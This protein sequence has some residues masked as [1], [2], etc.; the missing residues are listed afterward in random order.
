MT[1]L[2]NP[3]IKLFLISLKN[4]QA[5]TTN[6]L[7]YFTR[8][9]SIIGLS[10]VLLLHLNCSVEPIQT[11][12]SSIKQSLDTLTINNITGF[13]YQVSPDI[14][15]YQKLYIGDNNYFSFP[16]SLLKFS[17]EKA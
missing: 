7:M 9:I 15:S 13:S 3:W 6:Y 17:N 5:I 8:F 2:Q 14:S 16:S 10:S 1:L 11:D 12:L 4:K